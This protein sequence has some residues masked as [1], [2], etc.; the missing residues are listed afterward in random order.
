M[1]CILQLFWVDAGIIFRVHGV[2]LLAGFRVCH[3]HGFLNK[4]VLL[5]FRVIQVTQLRVGFQD[6]SDACRMSA[7]TVTPRLKPPKTEVT[8]DLF[9]GSGARTVDACVVGGADGL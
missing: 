9:A 3:H 1:A 5:G 4:P 6:I 8:S 7:R 2:P